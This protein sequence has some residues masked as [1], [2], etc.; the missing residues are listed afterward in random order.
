VDGS[1]TG[2][3]I[4]L[5]P[6]IV[7]AR[8]LD[9][10]IAYDATSDAAF[11]WVNGTNIISRFCSCLVAYLVNRS[12]ANPKFGPLFILASLIPPFSWILRNPLLRPA[13][14]SLASPAR[15]RSRISTSPPSPPSSAATTPLARWSCNYLPNAPWSTYS[16]YSY[17]QSSFTG[18]QLELMLENSFNLATYGN[19]SLPDQ[20]DWP[21]CLACGVI[22]RS[23]GRVGMEMPDVCRSCFAKHCWNG[24]EDD[25]VVTEVQKDHRPI[26]DPGL[27]Y[28]QWNQ[29]WWGS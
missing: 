23:V 15:G 8:K 22:K 9:F 11:S 7:P 3:T 12:P 17:T 18:N 19:G 4:P 20:S 10:I 24:E 27:T 26:L 14:N 29:T 1:E 5:R 2:E 25:T 21:A 6:L 28:D 16:N 13:S